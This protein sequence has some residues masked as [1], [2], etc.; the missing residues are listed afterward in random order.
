MRPAERCG[1]SAW[2]KSEVVQGEVAL[3]NLFDRI[4]QTIS[5][6]AL[7]NSFSEIGSECL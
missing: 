5:R 3:R 4:L 6:A 2:E 7:F 1:Q